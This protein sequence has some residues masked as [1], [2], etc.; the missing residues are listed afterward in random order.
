M[1]SHFHLT[2]NS[3]HQAKMIHDLLSDNSERAYLALCVS[4]GHAGIPNT[5]ERY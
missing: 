5:R 1:D 3:F 4:V 2:V